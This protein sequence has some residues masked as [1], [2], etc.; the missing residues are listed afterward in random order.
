M[1]GGSAPAAPNYA[2]IAQ[3]QQAQ[4]ELQYKTSQDQLDW[5]KQQYA[6][7][8]PYADRVLRSQTD[9]M[10]ANAKTAAKDRARY[11]EIYQPI[12][13]QQAETAQNWDSPERKTQMRARAA[14]T[15]GQSMDAADA[16]ATRQLQSYGV[17]PSDLR[18]GAI[19]RGSKL[20]RA[21]ATAG[22]ENNSDVQVDAQGNAL[23]SE[24]INVGK[25]YPGQ[26]AQQYGTATQS[27]A[28][29]VGTS[30]TTTGTYMPALGNSLGWAGM[31]NQSLMNSA[32]TTHMGYQDQMAQHQS[33]ESGS[34]GIGSLVG[35]GLGAA[36][37]FSDKRLKE[38]IRAVGKT[39][40]GQTLHEFNF[41][42]DPKKHI[43]LIAQEVEKKH[44]G[45]VFT[46]PSGYK[47]VDYRRAVPH[48]ADGGAVPGRGGAPFQTG[49]GGAMVPHHASVNPRATGDTVPAAL[50]V[51]EMVIPKRAVQ[52]HGEKHFQ[53]MIAKA[54]EE[55][56]GAPA[57]P[58]NK[59]MPG[60]A[61]RPT[62]VS[63]G[64]ARHGA[65]PVHAAMAL[66]R[67]A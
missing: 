17:N 56:S 43:G 51:G 66:R 64:A 18:M 24:A 33:N 58:K 14:A 50:E 48:M 32:S 9:Q 67:A 3:A 21:A 34:S 31:G 1:S 8:K 28:S 40:D 35:A 12:E 54:D 5:A 63:P 13:K 4:S 45:A 20:A 26:V 44:P 49:P 65:V 39:K 25:G 41:K 37:M 6:D 10:E 30:N 29:G 53:K 11:E 55:R 38:N 57:K 47:V 36:M 27:G 22:A 61:Q 16:A 42:G 15:V 62:F 59:P 2:P 23:R 19:N 60:N 46:H 7:V 52:W